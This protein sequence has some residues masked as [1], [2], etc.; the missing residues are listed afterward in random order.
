MNKTDT[1]MSAERKARPGRPRDEALTA[2]RQEEILEAS[3][4]IFAERGYAATDLQ[5]VADAL[6][7]GK[8][9]IYRYFP[10]K[11]DLFMAAVDR[12]MR[13]LMEQLQAV[14]ASFSDPLDGTF[15]VIQAYL[16]FYDAHPEYIELTIQ[17]RAAFKDRKRPTY[18]EYRDL[19]CGERIKHMQEMMDQGRMRK[20]PP[21]RVIEVVNNLLYGTIFTNYFAGNPKSL[22]QQARDIVDIVWY[23]SLSD[24]ERARRLADAARVEAKR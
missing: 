14:K 24:A 21:E 11:R 3:A 23:G 20:M 2:R 8:G 5:V 4:R 19:T 7:V 9:T 18:F 16:A 12:G 17:E 6:G 13:Q 10:S 15:Q 1:A 22:E